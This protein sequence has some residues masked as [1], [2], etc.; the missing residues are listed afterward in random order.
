MKP[1]TALSAPKNIIREEDCMENNKPICANC[2]HYDG[3]CFSYC[4]K[5]LEITFKKEYITGSIRKEKH[6]LVMCWTKNSDGSCEDYERAGL[7]RR[8]LN[9]L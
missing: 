6:G 2:K 9:R 7:L 4:T 1:K 5:N 8:L 3:R